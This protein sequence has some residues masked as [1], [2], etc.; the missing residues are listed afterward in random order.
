M[1]ASQVQIVNLAYGKFGDLTIQSITEATPQARAASVLWALTRDELLSSYPWK[2]ALKRITLDTPDATEPEFE[3]DYRYTLPA[4]CLKVLE[5]YESTSN[6]I[7]E[8]GYL[9]CSDEEIYL[10]YIAQITDTS[11]YPM[12]F[13]AALATKLA[14]EL[15]PKRSDN[16]QNRTVLLQEFDLTISRA[17]KLDAIEGQQDA[18]RG[19][20][21]LSRQSYSWQTEGR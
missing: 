11:L 10:R 15:C 6:Y 3:Y 9:L 8:G 19:E 21:D 7:V 17:Y 20:K 12:P 14:A 18:N 13:V 2:F 4:D 16:K 1:S 5:L